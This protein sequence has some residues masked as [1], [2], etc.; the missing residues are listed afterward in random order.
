MTG[1]TGRTAEWWRAAI[2]AEDLAPLQDEPWADAAD[3]AWRADLTD[4]QRAVLEGFED[5]PAVPRLKDL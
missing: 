3:E 4:E 2:A 5:Q 1:S